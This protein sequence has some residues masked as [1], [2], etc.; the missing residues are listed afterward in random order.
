M[1]ITQKITTLACQLHDGKKR[2]L[3]PRP[4]DSLFIPVH[5]MVDLWCELNVVQRVV[6]N[7]EEKCSV[8]ENEKLKVLISF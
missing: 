5:S 2:N 6:P 1:I 3:F 7:E 8:E 4:E